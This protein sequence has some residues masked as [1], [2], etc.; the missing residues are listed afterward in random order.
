VPAIDRVDLV[1]PARGSVA[2]AGPNGAGKTT[3]V[4]VLLGVVR[5][6]RGRILVGGREARL[7]NRRFRARV[8]YLSQRP[9]ELRQ[10]SIGDNLR[11][12]DASIPEARLLEVLGTVGLRDGLCARARDEL[13]ILALP[14]TGLSRGQARRVMLA[15]ALLREADLLVLDEPE[16]HLDAA[17]VVELT[18]ILKRVAK[19]RRVVAV[20]HD[21]QLVAFAD[22][23]IEL[24][25]PESA[26]GE[27]G[28]TTRAASPAPR[29]GL[30]TR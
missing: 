28:A 17:S 14:Y 13:G 25:A 21:R 19:E 22:T 11:A 9:F 3:L 29:S 18:A 7:D 24:R 23:V 5:P 30:E 1:L 12:F 26:G 15:R 4:H 16:A 8:A 6:D 20:V 2:I 27:R 10:G